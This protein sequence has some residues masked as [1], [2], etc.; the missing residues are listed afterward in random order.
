MYVR[1]PGKGA[2]KEG[3]I[4]GVMTQ[5]S[6]SDVNSLGGAERCHLFMYKTVAHEI[7]MY[8][9]ADHGTLAVTT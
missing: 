6:I 2:L 7:D 8:L 4:L 1:R 9:Q 3:V 5:I